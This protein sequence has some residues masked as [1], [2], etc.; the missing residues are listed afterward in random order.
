VIR[1]KKFI[2]F[3]FLTGILL[4]SELSHASWKISEIKSNE[5]D[6]QIFGYIYHYR[7][8]GYEN[9]SAK[10]IYTSG[11]RFI[12]S[13]QPDDEPVI[14]IYWEGLTGNSV[15]YPTLV[16]DTKVQTYK[17]F[18]IQDGPVI[19]RTISQSKDLIERLHKTGLAK[20]FWTEGSVERKTVVDFSEFSKGY[21]SFEKVCK[22]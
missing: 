9:N 11:I 17:D 14:A 3:L 16:L 22:F 10:K 12:C 6:K 15:Q 19:Y 8:R 1:L 4:F 5:N 21:R 13:N 20:I 2:C 18:W 7:S